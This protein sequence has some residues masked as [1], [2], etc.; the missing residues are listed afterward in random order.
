MSTRVTGLDIGRSSAKAI[1]LEVSGRTWRVVDVFEE[2][3]ERA[4]LMQSA[5]RPSHLRS[6]NRRRA[7]TAIPQRSRIYNVVL[8]EGLMVRR[9]TRSPGHPRRV[10]DGRGRVGLDPDDAYSA[11]VG[12]PFNTLREIEAV[13]PSQLEGK[14][15]VEIDDPLL[16]FMVSGRVSEGDHRVH[17]GRRACAPR[18]PAERPATLEIDRHLDPPLPRRL[19]LSAGVA[20][21]CGRTRHRRDHDAAAHLRR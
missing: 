15:L 13:L 19:G 1:I 21:G 3:I 17:R 5:R 2:G 4:W 6:G 9:A 8:V 7:K 18:A 12:L 10:R 16:D 11:V 14:L 20:R